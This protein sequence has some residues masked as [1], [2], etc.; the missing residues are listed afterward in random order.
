VR[1]FF[2]KND[3]EFSRVGML[4]TILEFFYAQLQDD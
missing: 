4:I 1:P 3:L 2:I